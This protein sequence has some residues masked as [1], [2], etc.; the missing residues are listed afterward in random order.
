MNI[1]KLVG[2]LHKIEANGSIIELIVR[3]TI[4]QEAEFNLLRRSLLLV[5]FFSPFDPRRSSSPNFLGTNCSSWFSLVESGWS[6][7]LYLRNFVAPTA[8]CIFGHEFI[9]FL[10][11]T[12]ATWAP[13][14]SPAWCF[15]SHSFLNVN[16]AFVDTSVSHANKNNPNRFYVCSLC[17][18]NGTKTAYLFQQSKVQWFLAADRKELKFTILCLMKLIIL[19]SRTLILFVPLSSF[20]YSSHI[21]NSMNQTQ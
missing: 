12:E 5:L 18:V 19:T 3:N 11:N 8:A 7:C 1:L 17:E 15:T 9:I 16:P 2:Y 21:E 20:T 10:I 13:L 14:I 6:C 4:S